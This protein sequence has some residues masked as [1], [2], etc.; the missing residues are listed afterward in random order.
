LKARDYFLPYQNRW[1][2]DRSRIKIFE[3]S[4]RIGGTFA[5]SY[6]DV[7]DCLRQK[8]LKVYFSSSDWTAAE[9][10]RDYCSSW[11]SKFNAISKVISD[12][13]E[14]SVK[15]FDEDKDVKIT[16]VEFP[17]T[18]SKIILLSSNPKAFRS[19]GGKIVWDEAAWHDHADKMWAAARP[20]IMWGHSM[21]ILSTHNGINSVFNKL[22]EK[23][24]LKDLDYSLHTVPITLAV[25][26]GLANRIARR[27]L[28][29]EETAEWLARERKGCLE[30]SD[31]LQEYLCNPQDESKAMLPYVLIQTCERDN[32]LLPVKNITGELYLG[33][34]VAR[35]RH[36]SVI[37]VLEKI[38]SAFTTRHLHVMQNTPWK[39]QKEVLWEML[40]LPG[41]CRACIDATGLGNQITEEAQD[42]F[43][44]GRVEAVTFSEKV[45]SDLAISLEN[46]FQDMSVLIPK[47][48]LQKESLHSVRKTTT[49]AGNTRY[50]SGS[51]KIGHGDHF[52]GL[53]LAYHAG[54]TSKGPT[55]VLSG[56]PW[57]RSEGMEAVFKGF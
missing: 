9:E 18:N 13:E 19:K 36:L 56:N 3:K 35:T 55:F 47:N 23:T 10:Y 28:S 7:Y 53:A 33:M 25:K 16:K 41:M 20:A 45:K 50:D 44:K 43:G 5:Q 34:D 21:R 15:F 42:R 39:K 57:P 46:A 26:E 24:K 51:S 32:L 11:A 17:S 37:Y 6:E 29:A 54:Q 48:D 8:D 49:S 1:L 38:G 52:W 14:N 4:R 22:I 27:E 12:E 40:A 31:W 30:E 2:A